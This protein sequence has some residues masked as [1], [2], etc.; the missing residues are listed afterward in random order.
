MDGSNPTL[1]EL[2]VKSVMRIC[3]TVD[4]E[5][6]LVTMNR[7]ASGRCVLR[8]RAGD[9]HSVASLQRA[10]QIAMPLSACSVGE[11]WVDG[12]LE[13]Q[14]EVYCRSEER[15]LARKLVA[16][17][18]CFKYSIAVATIL[19]FCGFAD[20]LAAVRLSLFPLNHDEL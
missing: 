11:S 3:Q 12:F 19:L 10:L 9:V 15:K 20:W 16:S 5:S 2:V 14:I 13:A 4:S 17:E 8:V 18:I 1:S 7:C 6:R